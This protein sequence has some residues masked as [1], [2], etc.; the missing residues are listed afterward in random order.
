MLTHCFALFFIL[1]LL[2]FSF[3]SLFFILW[4]K[5]QNFMFSFA[6][7]SSFP[8]SL[9]RC[10]PTN[11]L[12]VWWIQL[13]C[14]LLIRYKLFGRLLF[15]SFKFIHIYIRH[16]NRILVCF[17]FHFIFYLIICVKHV[18]ACVYVL[19]YLFNSSFVFIFIQ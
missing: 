5:I 9:S 10:Q 15:D 4:G 18:V 6:F 8:R 17:H 2:L 13:H 1:L 16:I 11:K 14:R 3:S 12:V 19:C 7:A